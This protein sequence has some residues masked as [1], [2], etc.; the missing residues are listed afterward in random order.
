MPSSFGIVPPT[1]PSADWSDA[2]VATFVADC[3]E[4][5]AS[6]L[7][8]LAVIFSESGAHA[9]A[10]NPGGDAT[11]LLQ[12][13]PTTLANFGW[14]G[15]WQQFGALGV[16]G[17]LPYMLRYLRVYRGK[18]TSASMVYLAVFLPACL[19]WPNLG[20]LT[21]I[22]SGRGPFAFA[23]LPNKVFDREAKGY[24]TLGDLG[25]SAARA[26][27]G[28]RWDELAGRVVAA[29]QDRPTQPEVV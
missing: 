28:P 20:P 23:Y 22:T 8:V 5:G 1:G 15:T 19:T 13:M 2:D 4:V 18:L 16:S 17:Q 10:H 14:R 29:M 12:F 3:I 27:K 21:V 24:I 9:E 7:D 6:P 25:A 26:S 11:G